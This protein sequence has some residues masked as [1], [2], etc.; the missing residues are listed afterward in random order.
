M[1]GFESVVNNASDKDRL[2]LVRLGIIAT[3]N[4]GTNK[5]GT[6]IVTSIKATLEQRQE[7][8]ARHGLA[9]EL[10][11]TDDFGDA[12]EAMRAAERY[13]KSG[14]LAVFGPSDSAAMWSVLDNKK[15]KSLPKLATF[16]TATN[17]SSTEGNGFFRFTASDAARVERILHTLEELDPNARQIAVYSLIAPE[18]SYS[19]GLRRDVVRLARER[20]LEVEEIG[21]SIPPKVACPAKR[22]IATIICAPSAQAVALIEELRRQWY[23]GKIFAF[24]S[25]ANFLKSEKTAG[26]V[27]V[28][29]LDRQDDDSTIRRRIAAHRARFPHETDPSLGSM[30]AAEAIASILL[31]RPPSTWSDPAAGRKALITALRSGPANGI[32]GPIVFTSAGEPVGHQSLSILCVKNSR[33]HLH[34]MP[35]R[36]NDTPRLPNVTMKKVLFYGGGIATVLSIVQFFYS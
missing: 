24:G 30:S 2:Q 9:V 18:S 21:F 27:L 8:F 32:A 36:G 19:Q 3:L 12:G 33:G 25:N 35:L 34:F 31:S 5:T 14:C 28:A 29:D 13:L 22:D 1:R 17:L 23:R 16:A 20:G 15:L 10:I 6:G 26:T 11:E 7:E 4:D